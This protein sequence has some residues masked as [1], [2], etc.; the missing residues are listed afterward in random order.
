[1]NQTSE[2][3]T[4]NKIKIIEGNLISNGNSIGII[5]ARFNYFINQHLLSEAVDTLTRIGQIKKKDIT[6]IKVPGTY[7]IPI[8]AN[9]IA[10]SLNYDGI[11]ILGT[12]IKGE[13]T[14]F[15]K[16][17][18][19]ITIKTSHISINYNIP[20]SMGILMIDTI[21]QGIN[22]SGAKLGNKGKEAAL[23]I[24]EMINIIKNIK[25]NI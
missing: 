24:L 14:H 25:S 16:L 2:K 8:I 15:E 19:D 1:M 22:R 12:I 3:S 10:Q 23:T 9:I 11:I 4:K 7:E 5:V 20:I 21:E 13:T 6:I 18:S 17:S